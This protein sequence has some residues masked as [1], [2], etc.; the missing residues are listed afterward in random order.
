MIGLWIIIGGVIVYLLSIFGMK[1]WYKISYF[2][3]N[4]TNFG[5]SFL[6]GASDVLITICPGINTLFVIIFWVFFHPIKN[7]HSDISNEIEIKIESLINPIKFF[8]PKNKK[9]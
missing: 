1:R 6:L 5:D 3:S 9:V 2:Q 7:F 4:G 8:Q